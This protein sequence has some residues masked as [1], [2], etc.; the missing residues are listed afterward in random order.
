MHDVTLSLIIPVQNDE[1]TLPLLVQEALGILPNHVGD[2][3]IL[4]V[5]QGSQ[6][7]TM[8]A[9]ARL[10]ADYEPV[11]V[12][13]SRRAG[14]GAAI[15]H[16]LAAA[17]G[18]CIAIMDADRRLTISDIGRFLAAIDQYD[19]V[20]GYR[21]TPTTPFVPKKLLFTVSQWLFAIQARDAACGFKLFRADL[22]GS[23]DLHTTSPLI[24]I[25]ILA[26]THLIGARVHEVAVHYDP[27]YEDDD[28]TITLGDV[29]R[30]WKT[31]RRYHRRIAT[32]RRPWQRPKVVGS[33]IAALLGGAYL[34]RRRR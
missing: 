2:F 34:L 20:L 1:A 32:T 21:P 3:E 14:Y 28:P 33:A 25:E 24:T 12:L 23:L 7:G 13:Q 29:W 9:A 22:L 15:L 6:D 5:D 30:L 4:I 31:M 19:A 27:A 10:A 8:R 16:G 11:A 26:K 18:N 17:R